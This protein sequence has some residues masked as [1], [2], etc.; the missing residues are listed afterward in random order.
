MPVNIVI[1]QMHICTFWV[2]QFAKG[3][4]NNLVHDPLQCFEKQKDLPFSNGITQS[5]ENATG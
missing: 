4:V 3:A 2:G 1:I 5:M